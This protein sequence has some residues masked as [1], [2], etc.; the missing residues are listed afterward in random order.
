MLCLPF[1]SKGEYKKCLSLIFSFLRNARGQYLEEEAMKNLT[2]L[3]V[4]T[5]FVFF[6]GAAQATTIPSTITS[7]PLTITT[8]SQLTG[9]VSCTVPANTDC[10]IF[11]AQAQRVYNRR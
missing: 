2:K 6:G 10:I 9:N 5:G 3:A 4:L 11:G 8:D 1:R 7:T